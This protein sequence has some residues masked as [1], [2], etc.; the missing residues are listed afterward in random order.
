M[1]LGRLRYLDLFYLAGGISIANSILLGYASWQRAFS[2]DCHVCH[3]VALL[4]VSDVM[5]SIAGLIASLILAV[6]CY[7]LYFKNRH[8]YVTLLLS[9]S[10]AG[11]ASFLQISQAYFAD[12]V[13]L[14]CLAISAGFYL[15]FG[16]LLYS[17][18]FKPS[19]G[20][21]PLCRR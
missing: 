1:R 18:V 7:L 5:I 4:T 10:F 15:V 3:Y 2:V 6:L 9:G 21:G 16:I 8:K 12:K 13:C 11:F 20:A 19:S 14:Q 17:I